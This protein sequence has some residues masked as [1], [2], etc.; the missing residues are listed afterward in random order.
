MNKYSLYSTK[1]YCYLKSYQYKYAN[2]ILFCFG[3]VILTYAI[4]NIAI[5]QPA[6]NNQ[7]TGAAAGAIIKDQMCKIL[8]LLE[9]PFGA[10]VMV[11][12]GLA[13]VVTAA[14]GAYKMAMSC[15]VIACGSYIVG[16]FLVLFFPNADNR[17][18]T[19][20]NGQRQFNK[21]TTFNNYTID[22][23]YSAP[24]LYTLNDKDK[25]KTI[26]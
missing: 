24:V 6:N 19:Y 22:F 5:A 17:C 4:A 13:A 14:M 9:G 7:G 18:N 3:I 2:V 8:I 16:A 1:I 23:N 21:S 12:A 10:L 20:K 26:L 25:S 15:V 11:V